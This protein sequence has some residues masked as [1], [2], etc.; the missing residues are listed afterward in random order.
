MHYLLIY[1]FV[2]DFLERRTPLRARHLALALLFTGDTV[3]TAE[4]FA[5]QDPYVT[6]GLVTQWRVRPWTTVVGTQAAMPARPP[7]P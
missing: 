6:C 2:P 4:R 1:E 3:G 7:A 5:Q